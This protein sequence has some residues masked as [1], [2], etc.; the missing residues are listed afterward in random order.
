MNL[1]IIQARMGSSRLPRKVLLPLLDKPVLWHVYNRLSHSKLIDEICISTSINPLDDVIEKFAKENE[2]KFH[3]G[4]ENNLVKRHLEATKKFNADLITRV[5]A[6]CPLVDPEIVDEVI[7][8][9]KN[10][11]SLDFVSNAKEKTYPEGLGV[12]VFPTRT[13]EKLLPISENPIFYEYFISNYI[14]EHPNI[15]KSEG[16]SLGKPNLL[17]WTLDYL[18]DYEFIKKVYEHLYDENEIFHMRDVLDL[19]KECPEIGEINSKFV[20]EFSHL[21]YQEQKKRGKIT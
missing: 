10:N 11:E 12:E 21:K 4:S 9:F 8:L 7:T 13:L 3:R 19:L 5:T 16:I 17:R 14:Y 20:S 15:F 1:G 2:I 18:E 6:D